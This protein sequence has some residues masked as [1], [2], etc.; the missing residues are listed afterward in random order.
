MKDKKIAKFR[1]LF[2]VA[3]LWNLIGA[4]SGHFSPDPARVG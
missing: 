2:I 3:A 4:I 1:I